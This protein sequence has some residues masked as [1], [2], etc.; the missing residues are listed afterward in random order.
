MVKAER[1]TKN[2]LSCQSRGDVTKSPSHGSRSSDN[3]CYVET[4]I[5]PK[6]LPLVGNLFSV[7]FELKK[8]KYHHSLWKCWSNKYGGLLGLR[9]GSVNTVVVFG[10]EM[11]KEVY[12]REVF[13][14]RPDGFMYTLRSFGKKLGIVFNDGSSWAKTRRIALKFMKSHGYG[15]RLM[16]EHISEECM[17]LVKMLSRTT[18]PV[19]ANNLFDVSIINIVWR[20]VAGKRYKLDDEN[21]KK[22]CDLITRCFKA[23]DI[24][25]GV[26]TFMPFLRYII[27]DIIGYTE[28]TTV[29]RALHKFLTETIREHRGTLDPDNPRDVIDSFLIE[30]HHN[31]GSSFTEEDLQVVC[32]DML[33]AG[34]ETVN[35]TAVYMLLH[36]VRERNVQ[37]RL[38]MEID[39]VIGKERT[40]SLSDKSRM[41]YTEAVI[42]ETLRI[43][44]IAPVGIPHMATADTQL[45]GYDIPKGT[46]ILIGLHD[47]HNGSHWKNPQ[48]FRPERFLT[49][50]G[51]LMQDETL[52]PFG[53]GKRRCIGEGLARSE[54]F[55]FIAHIMQKFHLI[56]PDGDPLPTAD[57]VG[58]ITLSAKPFKIQFLPRHGF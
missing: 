51:N 7:L 44:S 17:E 58:G 30:L 26:M 3:I 24:S 19:L 37:M 25:G 16:E 40:P 4:R 45:G 15:S 11:I 23:V 12:S 32:L 1:T 27:P 53:F 43:S 38:Q 2:I 52:K 39:E 8:V 55:L 34:V 29:H 13:D 22:L 46:F 41:V 20:L 56:V 31:N 48:D 42:L 47:L 50:E 6:P 35:N 21:L 49:K 10:K 54:L 33:E 36:L 9:L 14:G 18:K 57:P 5:G 28:M